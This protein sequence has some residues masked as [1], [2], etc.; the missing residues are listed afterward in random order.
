MTICVTNCLHWIGFHIVNRLIENDYQVDGV[1][2][3]SSESEEELSLMLGRNSSFTLYSNENAIKDTKYS[4]AV[5]FHESKQPIQALKTF[6]FGKDIDKPNSI[7]IELP[8]LFGEWMPMDEKGVYVNKQYIE[9]YSTRFQEEA[10]YI[11]DFVDCFM[12]WLKVPDLPNNISLTKNKN[13]QIKEDTLEKQL[14]IR[15]NRPI[16]DQIENL[17]KHYKKIKNYKM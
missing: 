10:I 9:F 5:L 7:N 14:Y 13:L 8:L 16:D 17:I 1:A 15:G 6:N 11:N 3:I 12:Q 4:D 2:D